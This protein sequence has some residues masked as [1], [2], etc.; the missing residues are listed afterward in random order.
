MKRIEGPGVGVG[1]GQG[2]EWEG[3]YKQLRDGAARRFTFKFNSATVTS[4]ACITIHSESLAVTTEY[5]SKINPS[6]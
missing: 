2:Y 5:N 3:R 6:Y 4:T 1:V